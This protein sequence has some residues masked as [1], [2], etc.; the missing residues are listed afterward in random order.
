MIYC[1]EAI[2][3]LNIIVDLATD[4]LF[5]FGLFF[6]LIGRVLYMLSIEFFFVHSP[7]LV[8]SVLVFM[9]AFKRA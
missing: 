2:K 3:H 1:V 8:G 4:D 9:L 7:K 5:C 6:T